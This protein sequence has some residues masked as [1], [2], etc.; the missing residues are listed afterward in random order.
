MYHAEVKYLVTTKCDLTAESYLLYD[1][2]PKKDLDVKS[3]LVVSNYS[4]SVC[5]DNLTIWYLRG[6]GVPLC[7]LIMLIAHECPWASF[8]LKKWNLKG[9]VVCKLVH[10]RINFCY[11]FPLKARKDKTSCCVNKFWVLGKCQLR[12]PRCVSQHE[13]WLCAVIASAESDSAQCLSAQSHWT[14]FP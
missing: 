11:A 3:H 9:N 6:L 12:I 1:L 5:Y 14:V 10:Q 2:R 7:S 13:V 8:P 4:A